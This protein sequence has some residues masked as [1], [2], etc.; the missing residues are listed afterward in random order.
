MEFGSG[1]IVKNTAG[2]T[3][4]NRIQAQT[5]TFGSLKGGAKKA[6]HILDK[7]DVE[8]KKA[9]LLKASKDFEGILVKEIL[10]SM[11]S[12]LTNGGM[13]GTGIAGEIYSDMMDDA[14]ASKIAGRG[15]MGLADI[16]YKQMVKSIDPSDGLIMP[17]QNENNVKE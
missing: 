8:A 15:D 6:S 16:I 1:T 2:M 11:R 3:R 10:K 5:A 14:V 9:K 13:F 7:S 4:I 17:I 12:T